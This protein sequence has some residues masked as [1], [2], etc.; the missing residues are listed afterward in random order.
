[1]L[2]NLTE[3]KKKMNTAD[4]RVLNIGNVNIFVFPGTIS[5]D[6]TLL[7]HIYAQFYFCSTHWSCPLILLV[8]TFKLSLIYN[9][10]H[11]SIH[12]LHLPRSSQHKPRRPKQADISDFPLI[13]SYFSR[14]LRINPSAPKT[15]DRNWRGFIQRRLNVD[16]FPRNILSEN[17]ILTPSLPYCP[18]QCHM[19]I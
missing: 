4:W 13:I 16:I 6:T 7:T 17:M 15:T 18:F 10:H 5:N 3:Q 11:T 1:M 9:K 2:A 19:S 14:S 8:F 12:S